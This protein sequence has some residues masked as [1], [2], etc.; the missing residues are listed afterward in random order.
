MRQDIWSWSAV[1]IAAAIRRRQISCVEAVQAAI[2][3]L[4]AVNRKVNAVT[5]DLSANALQAAQRADTI[6]ASGVT[7]GPLHGVPITI[8]ENVDQQRQATPN[9]IK[10]FEQLMATEDAPIVA[11]LRQAGAIIIGRTN[12][13][14]FSYRWCTDNPL[15]RRTDHWPALP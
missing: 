2:D 1:D 11:N 8:K 13:P 14:E 4:G 9:G 15:S 5:V 7:L 12:T 6:V 10:A 3:R